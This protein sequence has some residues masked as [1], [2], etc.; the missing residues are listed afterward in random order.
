MCKFLLPPPDLPS[1]SVLFLLFQNY[2]CS[3]WF[4]IGILSVFAEVASDPWGIYI[5][6]L[7]DACGKLN[8]DPFKYV[9]VPIPRTPKSVSSR[10]KKNFPGVIKL[11]DLEIGKSSWII[12]EGL[13]QS[14]EALKRQKRKAE[15]G[16]R[17][18]WRWRKERSKPE[19]HSGR[20]CWLWSCRSPCAKECGWPLE[21]GHGH[22]LTAGKVMGTSA[23]QPQ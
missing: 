4:Q 8:N 16:I 22:L 2:Y 1:A 13:F 15:K 18:M 10:G 11:K 7:A 3:N 12:Q 14:Q 21:A 17:V 6:W 23:L 20:R 9:D 19:R 5:D